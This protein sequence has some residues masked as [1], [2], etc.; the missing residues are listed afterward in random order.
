MLRQRDARQWR[1][2]R[3]RSAVGLIVAAVTTMGLAACS[4]APQ[5]RT[6]GG[7]AAT[8]TDTTQSL[9]GICPDTIVVQTSWWPE[10]EHSAVYQLLGAGYTLDSKTKSVTGPLVS[11]GADTGVKLQ[12]RAGGPAIGFQQVSA[13]MYVDKSITLG[14]LNTDEQVALSATQP[15]LGVVADMELDPQI[16]LW[17][18]AAHPT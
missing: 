4:S 1:S 13:Q 14:Q 16:L 12:I 3:R 18:P 7:Q 10:A 17:N 6:S 5:P 15:T 8:R 11:S 2:G 9:K